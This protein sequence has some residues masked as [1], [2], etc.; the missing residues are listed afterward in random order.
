MDGKDLSINGEYAKLYF[1]ENAEKQAESKTAD[2]FPDLFTSEYVKEYY[3]DFKLKSK[4]D[5]EEQPPQQEVKAYSMPN[6][7]RLRN[8]R[9]QQ[10]KERENGQSFASLYY[11]DVPAESVSEF[12]RI[13]EGLLEISNG[14]FTKDEIDNITLEY[15]NSIKTKDGKTLSD[16]EKQQKFQQIVLRESNK[17]E[18]AQQIKNIRDDFEKTKSKQGFIGSAWDGTKNFF[19]MKTG[20]EYV[21][22]QIKALENGKVSKEEAEK[23]LN[24]YK[25]GQ[26]QVVDVTADLASATVAAGCYAAALG[27][28]VTAPFTG[29]ASLGVTATAIAGATAAGAA[30]KAAIKGVDAMTGG[31]EYSLKEGLTDAVTGAING[32]L[33]FATAGAGLVVA[34]AGAKV[35]IPAA[36]AA[37]STMENQVVV[38][39]GK[40]TTKTTVIETADALAKRA[41]T[42]TLEN[43]GIEITTTASKEAMK[44]AATSEIRKTGEAIF[45]NASKETV[46]KFTSVATQMTANNSA[47]PLI[48]G[49]KIGFGQKLAFNTAKGAVDGAVFGGGVSASDYSIHSIANGT[50]FSVSGLLTHTG[51]GAAGGLVFGGVMSAG[52]T[53]IGEGVRAISHSLPNTPRTIETPKA[54]VIPTETRSL[55]KPNEQRLLEY[56]PTVEIRTSN[57]IEPKPIVPKTSVEIKST[58]VKPLIK[59]TK[60]TEQGLL[61]YKPVEETV[62]SKDATVKPAVEKPVEVKAA[63]VKPVEVVE[64]KVETAYAEA[65]ASDT[66]TVLKDAKPVAAEVKTDVK[67]EIKAE[68]LEEA[69]RAIKDLYRTYGVPEEV[70]SLPAEKKIFIKK[71]GDIAHRHYFL[72][73]KIAIA[74]VTTPETLERNLDL[75]SDFVAACKR[76]RTIGNFSYVLKIAEM[77][78]KQY[79]TFN[80]LK[81]D[82]FINSKLKSE[83]DI[84]NLAKSANTEGIIEL[85]KKYP[86][87]DPQKIVDTTATLEKAIF[88]YVQ[89]AYSSG[90]DISK[91]GSELGIKTSDKT[92]FIISKN[93]N[94]IVYKFAFDD[95]YGNLV[96]QPDGLYLYKED[97]E[98]TDKSSKV[99][100][101]KLS[102]TPT[103]FSLKSLKEFILSENLEGKVAFRSYN[104]TSMDHSTFD[105]PQGKNKLSYADFT[106]VSQLDNAAKANSTS[107]RIVYHYP[108]GRVASVDYGTDTLSVL[109]PVKKETY[110]EKS[111]CG[112]IRKI[113]ST[114]T[115][116]MSQRLCVG[117]QE[118]D[119]TSEIKDGII[120]ITNNKTG[121]S[122]DYPLSQ[123]QERIT[124]LN[125]HDYR[126][127]TEL[128]SELAPTSI[129]KIIKYLKVHPDAKLPFLYDELE[130]CCGYKSGGDN[131]HEIGFIKKDHELTLSGSP[132]VVN[133]EVMHGITDIEKFI[134]SPIK[135]IHLKE[136][137]ANSG[138]LRNLSEYATDGQMFDYERG[139][140]EFLSIWDT[141]LTY[142]KE[143]SY[144]TEAT[145]LA[146]PETSKEAAKLLMQNNLDLVDELIEG[147]TPAK[148]E[149]TLSQMKPVTGKQQ[150]FGILPDSTKNPFAEVKPVEVVEPKV[151]TPYA[152]AAVADA[153]AVVENAK[154][155]APVAEVEAPEVKPTES[156][157]EVAKA[158]PKT[159]SKAEEI[160]NLEKQIAEEKAK[161]IEANKDNLPPFEERYEEALKTLRIGYGGSFREIAN[162][163]ECIADNPE[164]YLNR[165]WAKSAKAKELNLELALKKMNSE[166]LDLFRKACK[167]LDDRKLAYDK[168]ELVQDDIGTALTRSISDGKFAYGNFVVGHE[169]AFRVNSPLRRGIEVNDVIR[170]VLDEG[171][172]EVEPMSSNRTVYRS[173]S[174]GKEDGSADFI[175]KI[176]NA[177]RGDTFID[178]GYSYSSFS[179]DCAQAC[180]GIGDVEIPR[181]FLNIDIPKGSKISANWSTQQKEA[182]FPRNAEFRILKPA[183][184]VS[185]DLKVTRPDGTSFIVPGEMEM[186]VEYLIPGQKIKE[187]PSDEIITKRIQEIKKICKDSY[188]NI[189]SDMISEMSESEYN[190]YL[191]L[192]KEYFPN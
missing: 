41:A 148:V 98:G 121:K 5:N 119:L 135:D 185:E 17:K 175:K 28:A 43:E 57:P 107:E 97:I 115:T 56:K 147:K 11:K 188:E 59:E 42:F 84:V 145:R 109:E 156:K 20:S 190:Q 171:F 142:G 62:I 181:V 67:P 133:H 126:D 91:K 106:E 85:I 58:E 114:K 137:K 72:P 39:L 116:G 160:A 12:K 54:E 79:E 103:D 176:I 63:E 19:G 89:E 65:A 36:K 113:K 179:K 44:K 170:V 51:M 131:I 104:P 22:K 27:G 92:G 68:E 134:N 159:I 124:N 74:K 139:L 90:Y 173:I 184:K 127:T 152:E 174:G 182:L 61:E 32:P 161:F 66:A 25:E 108:D 157:T 186:T 82:S 15:L 125:K 141:A 69:E 3:D 9:A 30:T 180:N 40:A 122:L 177:K 23:T 29:G 46:N 10:R 158:E 8:K 149:T 105:L 13:S 192:L 53:A 78:K 163:A 99:E 94:N 6:P 45:S 140:D 110:R 96:K 87:I 50:P 35:G 70:S 168:Y 191:K 120:R 93:G 189:L 118:L 172:K 146:Y 52:G 1:R 77:T 76:K 154:P 14:L 80:S 162:T 183:Q 38:G 150:T 7:H 64:P 16:E 102:E 60:P 129:L 83:Q 95:M 100:Y 112:E 18:K 2:N 130:S 4:K 73:Q 178:K 111:I 26:E 75:F 144:R 34:K 101:I 138:V 55:I 88:P 136:A 167:V 151:E 123:I 86:N 165:L 48:D 169:Y 166:E 24:S 155:I 187:L 143:M 164:R 33:A 47:T 153:K 128:F 49:A 31:R 21:E 132:H 71:F 117:D 37:L 81:K